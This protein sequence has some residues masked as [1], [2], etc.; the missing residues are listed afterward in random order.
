MLNIPWRQ[1][2][3]TSQNTT[4]RLGVARGGQGHSRASFDGSDMQQ[5]SAGQNLL[6][7]AFG[8]FQ[9]GRLEL[10]AELLRQHLKQFPADGSANH[11]LGSIYYRQGRL[12]EARDHEARACS[13]PGATAE[14]FN[15]LG[16][17][18]KAL[19]DERGAIASYQRALAL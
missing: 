5:N 18:Q 12:I 7:E 19:G 16:A 8:H 9:A 13:S 3:N 6:L 11:L 15:N 17:F 4:D 2:E 14:M 1:S 10:A